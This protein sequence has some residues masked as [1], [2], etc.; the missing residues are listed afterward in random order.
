MKIGGVLVTA[1]KEEILVIPRGDD[2]IVF[3]AIAV[4]DMEEF[5][6]LCPEP[7]PSGKFVKGEFV[8]DEDSPDYKAALVNYNM[9]RLAWMVIQTLKP[10]E[11]EWDTVQESNPRTWTNWEKDLRKAGLTQVEVNRVTQLVM[12]ANSLNED[13]LTKAREVFLR[14]RE[15]AA[16][17]SCCPSSEQPC[18]PSGEPACASA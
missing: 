4:P 15:Q 5:H 11:I 16:D 3:K 14:G 9:K 2:A 12:D 6:A 8:P 10:S 17:A 1:P 18:S 13:K 7:K